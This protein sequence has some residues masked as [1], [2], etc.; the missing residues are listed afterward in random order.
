ME[1]EV[2][3]IQILASNY[4]SSYTIVVSAV[5]G[6][7]FALLIA[8]V[9]LFFQNAI[10][11]SLYYVGIIAVIVWFAILLPY[12]SKIYSKNLDRID[13]LIEQVNKGEPLPSLR[14]LRKKN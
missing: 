1:T 2:L 5:F 8:F 9:T 3:K 6:F 12:A 7:A 14:E 13:K 4:N 11:L 10:D